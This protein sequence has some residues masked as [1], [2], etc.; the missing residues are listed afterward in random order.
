MNFLNRMVIFFMPLVPKPIVHIFSRRYVA[1]STLEDGVRVVRSLN[2]DGI[3][4][5]M[6]VLG[7]S[8]RNRQDAEAAVAEYIRVLHIIREQGLDCNISLKPTQLGLLIDETFC[9]NN[10][11]RIVSE[12]AQLGNFVRIDM[13]DSSCTTDTLAIYDQLRREFGNVGV[14]IQAYLRRSHDDLLA[15]V[16][17]PANF[18]ICKGIYV[19]KRRIAYKDPQIIN[20]NFVLLLE[21]AIK[22]GAYV[23]IATHDE[24]L[25]WHALRLIEA[26]SLRRDQY[27]FQMLLGVD[28]EL[29]RIIVSAGHRLR[30]YVPF[31][32]QWYAY[33]MRRMKENPKIALYVIKALFT[34][35]KA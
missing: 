32:R 11:R 13:E 29:R 27:E 30:V 20:D 7:E 33:C 18:R 15:L 1:G 12:A 14:A 6:D 4:A 19:E 24:R 3:L 10:I 16:Q 5:T 26:Y 25:V 8:T 9:L 2:Q 31:G 17:R 22:H 28:E 21:T 35:S 23:G 34:K